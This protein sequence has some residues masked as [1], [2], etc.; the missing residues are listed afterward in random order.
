[1]HT[2]ISIGELMR[3]GEAALQTGPFGTQLKADEYVDDG[4][5]VI[6][7]RNVGFGDV[8]DDDLEFVT[9][10]KAEQ[11]HHHR[12][13]PG[14]IVFGRKGAVE[15]HGLITEAH[16]GWVQGSDC[17]RLRLRTERVDVRYLSYFLRTKAHGDWMHALCS[18][19]ATMASLNQDIVSR[20]SFPAPAIEEQRKIAAILSAYDDL[21]A[22]NHRR[23]ALLEAMAE[24]IYREWFVRMR[25][26]GCAGEVFA[27]GVPQ[28]WTCG[29]LGS[30]CRVVKGKSYAADELTDDESAMPFV[31][32]KSFNRG[33]GYRA[34]GLK[35]YSGEYKA[36][37]V[38]SRGDIVVAVTDMTQDRVVVGQAARVPFLGERGAVI[39][40]DVVRIVPTRATSL[41]LYCF[42]RFSGFANYIKEFA[43]GANVLHLKPDLIGR[44]IVVMPPTVLQ[45]QFARVIDPMVC[46]TETLAES[47]EKLASVRAAL[48]PRLISGKL[49]VDHLD[50]RLPPSMRAEV[51]AVA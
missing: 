5:P 46:E 32:L 33:G 4:V 30:H 26:P 36:D 45:E 17:L 40:L 51:E 15:R 39:S 12:L 16:E 2:S 38:V 29:P 19:G 35:H 49:K 11:L 8:R 24:E 27:K 3:T 23:I 42:L 34:D 18:F 1:M 9:E 7:V 13:L 14:D 6:N 44:Q 48:L 43:N 20:I 21:I 47:C 10:A 31:T 28:S 50:I 41:F 22:N 37:Q 25:F